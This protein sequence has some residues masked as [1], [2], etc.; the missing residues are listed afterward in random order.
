[1]T[2]DLEKGLENTSSMNGQVTRESVYVYDEEETLSE[3]G[4]KAGRV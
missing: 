3:L 1:M 2:E 4:N